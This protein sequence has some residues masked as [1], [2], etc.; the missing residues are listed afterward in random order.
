MSKSSPF[1][2]LAAAAPQQ[3]ASA[4]R[5]VLMSLTV[6]ALFAGCADT[7]PFTGPA[8]SAP[9]GTNTEAAAHTSPRLYVLDCGSI[10]FDSV[11]P[12]GLAD[13]ETPV[14]ELVVPCY[15][16]DHPKGKL[17]WD[18]GLPAAMAGN[19][20]PVPM[21]GG[22]G[23]VTYARSLL[24]QLGDLELTPADIDKVAFSHMHFDH[25]G[26]ANLFTGSQ[27]LIQQN[28]FTAAFEE[29]EKFEGVFEP[30]L[31]ADMAQAR[32]RVLNG[33]HDVFGDGTV[34]IISAP[35]HTPGH[36]VLLL[37]LAN[38]GP[39]V[40]S[41]DLYHFRFSRTNRRTPV[42]NYNA[43]SSLASMDRVEALIKKEGAEFWIQHDKALYDT[44]RLSPAY[45]D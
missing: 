42:F 43:E 8:S 40:L 28:E 38:S 18:A 33:D 19:S 45:Y 29:A 41:G 26:S 27:L 20:T 25:T 7:G 9:L 6:T 1:S 14:R 37:E 11:V 13:D 4:A 2:R 10:T 24:D 36:Q 30:S 3:I 21:P 12:F 5:K 44:L 15:L 39:L 23:T 35:G 34:Q 16:I 22:G 17:L 31:Y 32:R